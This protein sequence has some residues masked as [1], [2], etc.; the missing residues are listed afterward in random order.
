M[1]DLIWDGILKD[2]KKWE[3][4]CKDKSKITDF[5]V[6]SQTIICID[7]LIEELYSF[8]PDI[9]EQQKYK[10]LKAI[11]EKTIKSIEII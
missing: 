2:A 11:W 10:E 6:K 1:Q 4:F 7:C 9:L 8:V 5:M 3:T